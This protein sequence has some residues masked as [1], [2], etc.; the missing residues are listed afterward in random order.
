MKITLISTS[1]YPS[2][3]GIRTV[4]SYLKKHDYEVKLVFLTASENYKKLYS[5]KVLRQLEKICI[6]SSIIGV[7]AYAS[8]YKRASQV[9]RYLKKLRAPIIYGG[10]HPT[11]SPE[12]CIKEADFVCVGEGEE[13]MLELANCIKNKKSTSNIK[14]I[15]V[16]Q[17]G[18]VIKNPVRPVIE[19]LDKLPFADYEI[20]DHYILE[21][22]KIIKFQE[23]HFN[24]QI[25]F[26]TGRG[27]PYSCTY[28]SNAHFNKLY[29]RQKPVRWHSINY[30]IDCIVNLKSKFKTLSYFDIRDDTFSFRPTEQIK[31][32]N[33]KY[34]E[35]VH[36]R[37]KCLG[38]PKTID[39][40]KIRLLVDA[41]CTDI[42][43]GIQGGERVNLE[44]YKRNQT[45]EQVLRSAQIL[46]KYKKLKSVRLFA[47]IKPW[48]NDLNVETSYSSF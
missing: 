25:F 5:K 35:K 27:C 26:L 22:N 9:I 24:G 13:A 10:V 45:D 16:N 11:I 34:K 20:Q 15:W 33:Q 37:F 44:V 17:N 38:D 8:T 6:G 18:L 41:G 31:E 7:S 14:N 3:Q 32:F 29:P 47:K 21:R 30:I 43:I 40:E 4:S 2:D 23:R 1:T 39:D 42:I 36:M 19:D 12:L 46:N 28:C 48:D